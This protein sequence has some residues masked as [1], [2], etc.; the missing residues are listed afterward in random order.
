MQYFFYS[1]L[2]WT[3]IWPTA[4]STGLCP[5]ACESALSYVVFAGNTT[6]QQC[7][8]WI[9]IVSYYSCLRKY[10][11]EEADEAYA[12]LQK[13]CK[14]TTVMP[15][16]ADITTDLEGLAEITANDFYR[17]TP[18]KRP[19]ALIES[20]Y[21]LSVRTIVSSGAENKLWLL[22]IPVYLRP[23]HRP[24]TPLISTTGQL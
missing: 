7:T 12:A 11:L 9:R 20:L 4:A 10:C 15:K 1:F 22:L 2:I 6:T 3:V 14:R 24:K 18:L 8:N 23:V 21:S 19:V 13:T 5:A 16:T 17:K